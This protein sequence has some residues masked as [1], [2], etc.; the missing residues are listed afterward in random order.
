[1][2]VP[3]YIITSN[4]RASVALHPHQHL[5][6]SVHMVVLLLVFKGTAI[7]FSIMT[8]SVYTPTNSARG[9]PFPHS[10]SNIYCLHIFWWWTFW[11]ELTHWKRPRCWD[12]VKAG[13]EGD[14][15]GWDGWMAS[16]IRWTW[17]WASSM[18]WWWTGTSVML[19][20]MGLSRVLSTTTVQKRRVKKLA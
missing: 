10:L 14:D 19:Q 15:K 4:M 12:R 9:V 11:P 8:V 20:S 16:S 18:S 3:F 13:W 17:V 1:M 2:A 5:I 7:L 6:W